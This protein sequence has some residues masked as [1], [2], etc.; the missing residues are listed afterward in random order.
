MRKNDTTHFGMEENW[1]FHKLTL[2]LGE[3]SVIGESEQENDDDLNWNQVLKVAQ[4]HAILSLLYPLSEQEGIP[5]N[6]KQCIRETSV[7]TV[8]QNYRLLFLTHYLI[9]KMREAKVPVIVLKGVATAEFYPV[10]ELRKSGD[11]DL[12]VPREEMFIQAIHILK[13]MGAKEKDVPSV[14]HHQVFIT[15]E[16]IEIELHVMLAEPFDD[17]KVN[18]YLEKL[19]TTLFDKVCQH[20]I[21]EL[22]FP[23][24]TEGYHA[25]YLLLH[26]LQH[27]L[28]S[29][30][31]LKLLCD[32]VVFWNHTIEKQEIEIYRNCVADSGLEGFSDMIT[33]LSTQYLGL[34]ETNA[35]KILFSSCANIREDRFMRDILDS[36]EFGQTGEGRLVALRGTKVSDYFREFHHQMK[37]NFP[38]KSRYAILFP[39][40]WLWTLV[41]FL[42]NNRRIRKVSLVHVLKQ[43]R[44]RSH[45]VEKLH[46][47]QIKKR[48]DYE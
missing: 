41:R 35:N 38:K 12:L 4:T 5:E 2:L 16:G 1:L 11:I 13:E 47:F 17:D 20:K 8:Q 31:G 26:M 23:V 24:L 37:L 34:K 42:R 7:T 30:F 48:N 14:N 44:E 10:P 21:M 39:L 45:Y 6:V 43:A 40:L 33:F 9:E 19:T 25:Y 3:Q 27:F 18:H 36:E 15:E 22:D 32:W 29:G 28:R 46:L